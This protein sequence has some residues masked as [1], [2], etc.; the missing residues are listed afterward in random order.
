[1]K[2]DLSGPIQGESECRTTDIVPEADGVRK[3]VSLIEKAQ[4]DRRPRKRRIAM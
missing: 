2:T 1:M 4:W 3:V